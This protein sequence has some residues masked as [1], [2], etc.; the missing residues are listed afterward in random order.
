MIR[1]VQTIWLLLAAVAGFLTTQVPLYSGTLV[2]EVVKKYYVTENLLLFALAVV[3]ALLALIG[4]F[5]YKNRKTQ[6]K[7]AG[8]G[9]VISIALIALEVWQTGNFEASNG[10]LKGSY[11]WG[12]LLPISMMIFFILALSGIRKDEK[13][14]KSLDR[15]R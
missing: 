5:L 10:V 14:I 13:L 12:A 3:A 1:R 9:L 7:F 2:G 15:L 4:I 6:L 11:Y 8:F